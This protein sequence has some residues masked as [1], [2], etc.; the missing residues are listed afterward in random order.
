MVQFLASGASLFWAPAKD[1]SVP[2]LVPPDKLEQANQLSLFATYGTAPVAGVLFSLLAVLSTA[3]GHIS[4]Y[5]STNQST[6]RCTS[7]RPCT[8][9]PR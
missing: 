1:A 2:N 7:R 5:F 6:C 4:P 9:Y 8:W 3:L